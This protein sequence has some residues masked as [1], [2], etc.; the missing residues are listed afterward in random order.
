MVL[1]PK[2]QLATPS[3]FVDEI[4]GEA[5]KGHMQSQ[6]QCRMFSFQHGSASLS[7]QQAQQRAQYLYTVDANE[8]YIMYFDQTALSTSPYVA[9]VAECDDT[10]SPVL[11]NYLIRQD[12]CCKFRI[13]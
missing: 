5:I 9:I 11:L 13:C 10:S 6:S 1:C 12:L 4:I 8:S 7:V 3:I 2:S